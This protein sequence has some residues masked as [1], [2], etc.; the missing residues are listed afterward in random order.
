[1]KKIQ[2]T[3]KKLECLQD[4]PQYNPTGLV[5]VF[6]DHTNL[7]FVCDHIICL[8]SKSVIYSDMP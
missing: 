6:P 4:F 5:V 1:M 7:L 8:A 2:S 3:V